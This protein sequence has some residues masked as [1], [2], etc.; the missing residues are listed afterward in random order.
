MPH[1]FQFVDRVPP[2]AGRTKLDEERATIILEALLDNPNQWAR[3]PIVYLYPDIEGAK[4]DKL[5]AKARSVAGRLQ[6]ADLKPFNEYRCEA[7]SREDAIYMRIVMT[8]RELREAGY[9][10]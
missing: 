4:V 5:K 8:A 7:K 10:D 3:V 2:E 9:E 6:R 1:S